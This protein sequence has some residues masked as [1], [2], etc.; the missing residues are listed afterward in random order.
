MDENTPVFVGDHGG[1]GVLEHSV[2]FSDPTEA[3]VDFF[4][5]HFPAVLHK[6]ASEQ[7]IHL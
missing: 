2:P 5:K 1:V 6:G 4:T 7:A 3:R